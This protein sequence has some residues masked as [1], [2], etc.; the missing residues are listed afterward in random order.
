MRTIYREKLVYAG[1]M[2]FGVVY[3]TFPKAG[4][5]R[6]K[7]KTT[8]DIQE[9]LN[10]RHA[11]EQLTWLIHENFDRNSVSVTLTYDEGW[12]PDSERRFEKDIRNYIAKLKRIYKKAGAEFKYIV[13][14]AFGELGR[15]HLH[16]IVSGGVNRDAIE[17]AWNFGRSNTK[18]LEYNECGVIDL[19]VYLADQR[20]FGKRRWSGSKN[21]RQPKERVNVHRYSRRELKEIMDSGNPYKFFADSYAEYS[22]SEFPKVVKNAINGSY[23]MTFVMYKPDS[24][25]LEWYVR[26]K[27]GRNASGFD[28]RSAGSITAARVGT[29]GKGRQDS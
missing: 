2:I 14:K 21:L 3:A 20:H 25:N 9:A 27:A 13:I 15:C 6:K 12:Y 22:L 16:L 1:D 8:S 23:Y 24:V 19:S 26:R 17:S 10:E 29:V 11:R 4:K 5:R 7:W 18:R 28:Q